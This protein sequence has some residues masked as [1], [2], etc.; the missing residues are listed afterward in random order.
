MPSR[1]LADFQPAL[2][3]VSYNPAPINLCCGITLYLQSMAGKEMKYSIQEKVIPV[4]VSHYKGEHYP[5]KDHFTERVIGPG[6]PF[7]RGL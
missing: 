3:K 4:Q 5:G 7:L 1:A 6:Q 2:S